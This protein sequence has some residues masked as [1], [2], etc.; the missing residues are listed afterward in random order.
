MAWLWFSLGI[1]GHRDVFTREVQRVKNR[2]HHQQKILPG[3]KVIAMHALA[4]TGK[5]KRLMS[6]EEKRAL[7]KKI[8][9]S[10]FAQTGPLL[11]ELVIKARQSDEDE[12]G[13]K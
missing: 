5:I 10:P 9:S 6:V 1:L 8:L 12:R 4:Q 7:L 2:R 13:R 3:R 11:S